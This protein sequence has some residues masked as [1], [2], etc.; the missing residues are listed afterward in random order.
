MKSGSSSIG[1]AVSFIG[2]VIFLVFGFVVDPTYMLYAYLFIGVIAVIVIYKYALTSIE[3]PY[4]IDSEDEMHEKEKYYEAKSW[5]ESKQPFGLI[6]RIILFLGI[7]WIVFTIILVGIKLI[8]LKFL[9]ILD[10]NSEIVVTELTILALVM[11]FLYISFLIL[12]LFKKIPEEMKSLVSNKSDFFIIG[13]EICEFFI[14]GIYGLF[15]SFISIQEFLIAIL[16][17][18]LFLLIARLEGK[19][20]FLF[21]LNQLSII[22]NWNLLAEKYLYKSTDKLKKRL[23][24]LSQRIVALISLLTLPIGLVTGIFSLIDYLINNKKTS[25]L[26]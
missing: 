1:I 21:A 7:A 9:I 14:L 25:S 10:M 12:I 6:T 5:T 16:L 2:G 23:F 11:A 22:E 19:Y 20:F 17:L 13:L 3:V 8:G 24:G 18:P 15:Q 4:I 26:I